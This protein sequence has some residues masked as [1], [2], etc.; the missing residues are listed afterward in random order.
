MQSINKAYRILATGFSFAIFGVGGVLI[1]L[2]IFLV[3]ITH[4]LPERRLRSLARKTV[5]ASFRCYILFMKSIGLLHYEVHGL[6]HLQKGKAQLV[7]A[8]HPSLLDVVF[9]IATLRES[10]CIVKQGLL[11]NPFTRP[12][13]KAAQFVINDS[14]NLVENCVASLKQQ[15]TLVI[16]PEGTRSTPGEPLKFLRGAANVALNAEVDISLAEIRCTPPTLLKGQPWYCVPDRPPL[17][18]ITF[19]PPLSIQPFLDSQEIPSKKARQLTGQL[20][21]FFSEKLGLNATS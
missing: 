3:S 5:S 18:S 12:P 1:G 7:I 6:E 9:L 16:F 17:F 20:Q 10:N 19:H 2:F 4:L 14:A 8:N 13:V 15:E 21:Q 11:T